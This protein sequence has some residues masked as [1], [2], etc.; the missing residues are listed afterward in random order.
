[1]C[2]FNSETYEIKKNLVFLGMM[3]SGKTSMGKIVSK[4]W[5]RIH[6]CWSRDR[7][8]IEYEY[9]KIFQNKG[10]KYF[11]EVEETITLRYWKIKKL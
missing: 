5:F 4:T 7:K 3:G 1:M 2:F 8:R 10:E 6:W 11:R 9:F